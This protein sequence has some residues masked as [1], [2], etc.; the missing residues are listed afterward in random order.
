MGHPWR[1]GGRP[2][3][4]RFMKSRKTREGRT[5]SRRWGYIWPIARRLDGG[6]S[7]G[8]VDGQVVGARRSPVESDIGPTTAEFG[9]GRGLAVRAL[10][11]LGLLT[12]GF[13][14]V[15]VVTDSIDRVGQQ[16]DLVP[17][18]SVEAE[19]GAARPG[20]AVH[21]VGAVAALIIAHSGLVGLVVRPRRA[22]YAMQTGAVAVAMLIT[23]IVI[24]DPDNLGGQAGPVDPAFAIMAVPPLA[25][26]LTAAPWRG[27][28]PV[29]DR[30]LLALST[31]AL[32][33]VVYGLDQGLM[34]RNT[35]PP[36]ADPHHQAH[37]WAMSFLGLMVALVS[38][39]TMLGGTGRRLGATTAGA[40]AIA[41]G[42][43]SLV[44]TDAAS[45]L[46][47]LWAVF[48]AG[49]GTALLLASWSHPRGRLTTQ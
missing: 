34:Q 41:V 1:A 47:P 5:G 43:V 36:L 9:R 45:A 19:I 8:V 31:V 23:T 15:F 18:G 49:W 40:A 10:A 38:V 11:V 46:H 17:A 27:W 7:E 44:A 21:I 30:R 24:G 26:A 4:A 2:G 39:G 14:L 25:A 48:A 12:V 6:D 35:W 37:W 28:R 29:R 32:G 42:V 33:A 22:G 16:A 20:E 3:A 13:M